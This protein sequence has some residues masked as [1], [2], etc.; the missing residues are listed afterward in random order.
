MT[1]KNLIKQLKLIHEQ[2][3]LPASMLLAI[4]ARMEAKSGM[5][6]RIGKTFPNGNRG[7]LFVGKAGAGKTKMM[8]KFFNGLG[9]GGCNQ[10]GQVIGKW[11]TS[12]GA[13]TGIGIYE[14]LEVYNDSIIFADELSLD[15]DKHVHVL[16]QIA[17]GELIRPRHGNIEST[18]FSGLLIGATNSVKLPNNNRDLEH[19]LATLDRFMVVKTKVT[20]KSPEETM[21]AV[22]EDEQEAEPDWVEI[23]KALGRDTS[24]DL[25]NAEKD[26]LRNIWNE[27]AREILDPTRAQWRNSHAVLDI[28]LFCKRFFGCKDLT[29]DID[30]V[31]FIR[32]MISDCV[33]FNPVGILWLNPTEQVIYDCIKSKDVVSTS[34]IISS[35][36]NVG[37]SIS[38]MTIS[39]II[40]KMQES[41]L[42][43][44][45][46]H[47][48]YSTKQPSV[49]YTNTESDNNDLGDL[50]QP[51]V[52]KEIIN[53]TNRL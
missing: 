45:R 6:N 42:I 9:L 51:I 21:S 29:K 50:L 31:E 7:V 48:K 5:K 52:P 47:G 36:T 10:D 18:P 49:P 39:R 27:K 2:T 1:T 4:R 8:S 17:N 16:K 43:I 35:V 25:N 53:L 30:A 46:S 28:F 3:S 13:S 44:R 34:E 12:T 24:T 33:M 26:L 15:T 14:V 40:N 22:L 19:L 38:R 37:I 32:E 23:A 20:A 41:H 11:V